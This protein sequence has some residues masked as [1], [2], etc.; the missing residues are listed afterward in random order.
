M[1]KL[2]IA[3]LA[4]SLFSGV[5]RAEQSQE[6]MN[7]EQARHMMMLHMTSMMVDGQMQVMKL[8]LSQ[9]EAFKKMLDDMEAGG[10]QSNHKN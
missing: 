7:N 8:Q 10:N 2:A 9:L 3:A 6:G 4:I 1:K 5:A